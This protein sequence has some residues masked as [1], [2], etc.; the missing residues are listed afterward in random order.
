M[1]DSARGTVEIGFIAA[2]TRTTKRAIYYYFGSKEG[3]YVAV[4]EKAY[5][6]IR[7]IEGDL[8]LEDLDPEQAIQSLTIAFPSA[9]ET[10]PVGAIVFLIAG[11]GWGKPVPVNV[12]ALRPGRIGMAMVAAGGPIANVVVA[13]VAAVALT[14]H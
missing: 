11:F 6:D 9:L 4:L 13:V 8:H 5:G 14:W 1:V 7:A 2:R 3:L 10:D 12:Y